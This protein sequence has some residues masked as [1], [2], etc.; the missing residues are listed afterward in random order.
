MR[1]FKRLAAATII[2]AILATGCG[3]AKPASQTQTQAPAA[4]Q[5]AQ[6]QKPA[7]TVAPTVEPA[8]VDVAAAQGKAKY[9]FLFIGDG[10]GYPQINTAEIL[11]KQISAPGT[12]GV[13]RMEFTKF[14]NSGSVTTFDA[15]SFCPDS[16]STGTAMASGNKTLGGVINMDVTKTEKFTIISELAKDAGYKVGVISSVSLDH[17][18][19][20]CFYAKQ[21][22]RGDYYDIGLQLVNSSFDFFGGG[23]FLQPKGKDGDKEDLIAIAKTNGF[24]VPETNDEIMALS[25]DS[26]KVLAISP[27]L[28]DAQSL[29]YELDRIRNGVDSLSLAQYVQKGIDVLDNEDGFF[30]MTEGGKID[31]ACHA[32][33]AASAMYDTL[34]LNEAVQVAVDFAQKHPAETLVLVT[35]DH[36]TGGLTIGFAA[37]G[38]STFFEKTLSQNMSFIEFDATYVKSMRDN[39][40]TFEDA[41]AE[42]SKVFGLVPPESGDESNAGMTLTDGEYKKL[43]DAYALSMIPSTDRN[44]DESQSILYGTYEPLSVTCTHILNNKAGIGWTSYAHTGVPIPVFAYGEKAG[45]FGGSYDNTDIFKKLTKVMEL[46]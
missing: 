6:T 30:L 31:W 28:A 7:S 29:P 44:Y 26:G 11:A 18:T 4:P 41:M 8:P 21:A 32:N 34:S 23:G 33:D 10:M 9:V 24:A 13:E 38:Y 12:I 25:G 20:A 1:T 39:S 15:E 14:E 5:A 3:S 2:A 36:E 17:A 16:A 35:G 22:S 43:Q 19:P 46:L 45:I 37:T 42:I 40:A 27:V